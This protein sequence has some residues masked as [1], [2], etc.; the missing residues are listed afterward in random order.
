MQRLLSD[1]AHKWARRGYNTII[2]VAALSAIVCFAVTSVGA[3]VLATLLAAVT[4]YLRR[5]RFPPRIG[6]SR[7]RRHR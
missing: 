6:R 1:R 3:G 4:F 5:R 7:S 2:M